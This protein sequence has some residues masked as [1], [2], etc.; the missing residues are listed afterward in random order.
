MPRNDALFTPNNLNFFRLYVR[1]WQTSKFPIQK[2][3]L[4]YKEIITLL[5]HSLN[6]VTLAQVL[7]HRGIASSE[8]ADEVGK[9]RLYPFPQK[10]SSDMHGMNKILLKQF[11]IWCRTFLLKSSK[12][13]KRTPP[14][15][16]F[17]TDSVKE[18][19][20][21]FADIEQ[22]T[23][24]ALR[25]SCI[26]FIEQPSCYTRTLPHST[27]RNPLSAILPILLFFP[28]KPLSS[29]HL[30]INSTICRVCSSEPSKLDVRESTP[31]QL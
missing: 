22:A 6:N 15:S 2:T 28:Q 29:L 16:I 1:I 9:K 23:A 3:T 20:S 19:K 27:L 10:I 13:L 7:T 24:M 12:I 4:I 25:H 14:P 17:L 5:H 31:P 18:N 11:D 21:Y 30:L 8:F 26:P